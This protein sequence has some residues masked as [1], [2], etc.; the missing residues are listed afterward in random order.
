MAAVFALFVV[1]F[2]RVGAW[3]ND[4]RLLEYRVLSQRI[5]DTIQEDLNEQAVFLDQLANAFSASSAPITGASFRE[6]VKRLPE[7]FPHIQAVEWGPKLT[8]P[9]RRSFETQQRQQDPAFQIR[10]NTVTGEVPASSR[11]SHLFSRHFH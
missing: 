4:Q 7:N 9:Q 5:S 6:L 10:E 8:E 2:I 1:I 3:E 11:R